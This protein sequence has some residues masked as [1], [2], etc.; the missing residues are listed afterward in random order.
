[1]AAATPQPSQRVAKKSRDRTCFGVIEEA[2]DTARK[3]QL[4][5]TKPQPWIVRKLMIAVTLGLMGYAAYV[6]I[7]FL[8]LPMIRGQSN[9]QGSRGRG[10][11]LLVVFSVIYL[12]MV[13]AYAKVVLTSPG[14]A[15]DHVSKVERPLLPASVPMRESWNS[16]PISHSTEAV[17]YVPHDVELGYRTSSPFRRISL[18][19]TTS[20]SHATVPI[21]R[22]DTGLAGPSYEDLLRR[23]G[24]ST[25]EV[26]GTNQGASDAIP[27]P[28]PAFMG[29]SK[30]GPG[31]PASTSPAPT[32]STTAMSHQ[33]QHPSFNMTNSKLKLKKP[34]PISPSVTPVSTKREQKWME[35]ERVLQSLNI[36]RRPP[37]TAVLQPV[38][39]YCNTDEILKPYRAHHCRVCGTCVLKYDHHCPWI[40]QCVGARN[41]KFFVNFCLVAAVFSGYTFATILAY[42]VAGRS[43]DNVNP[44]EVVV[45]ALCVYTFFS[46]FVAVPI[47][48][49][50]HVGDFPPK[51]DPQGTVNSGE[52]SN[53]EHERA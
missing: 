12:W 38:H 40:G 4:D 37:T 42:T 36:T 23:D 9:S 48:V 2:A 26:Q 45:I 20:R 47:S 33:Q 39:R 8:C 32:S 31:A 44:Q 5:R 22:K 49:L 18:S 28:K 35:R 13:W 19:P 43:V 6:Y 34:K 29:D 11:A 30:G 50:T 27:V 7:Q 41:H 14:Y 15:R 25:S 3:K 16:I 46:S 21:T 53:Q 51:Y 17:D 24:A 1:M 52:C 10:I